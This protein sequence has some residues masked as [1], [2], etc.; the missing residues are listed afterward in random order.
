MWILVGVVLIV[1]KVI[2]TLRVRYY[3]GKVSDLCSRDGGV[4]VYE[5]VALQA[6]Q[7]DAFGN[8]KIPDKLNAKPTDPYYYDVQKEW[9]VPESEPSSLAMWRMVISV[10]RTSDG[11]LLGEEVTYARRGG[12]PI[13]PWYPSSYGCAGLGG[14]TKAVF[15]TAN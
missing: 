4:R 14:L 2:P 12:D 5:R 8:A 7:F 13:G 1:W 9:I 15:A 3:D 6:D 10:R 11:K